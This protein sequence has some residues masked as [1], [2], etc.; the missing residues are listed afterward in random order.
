M[1]SITNA[2]TQQQQD[3]KVRN[4]PR[5]SKLQSAIHHEIYGRKIKLVLIMMVKNYVQIMT[6]HYLRIFTKRYEL[7]LPQ[8]YH[9]EMCVS[10]TFLYDIVIAFTKFIENSNETTGS[11]QFISS[12]RTFISSLFGKILK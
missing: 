8:I 11:F 4:T 2:S 3:H 7:K 12:L 10:Y 9:G 6:Y 5:V 1:V